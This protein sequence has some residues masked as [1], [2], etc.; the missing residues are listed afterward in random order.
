MAGTLRNGGTGK[1]VVSGPLEFPGNL[2]FNSAWTGT[3]EI[4]GSEAVSI[5]NAKALASTSSD[6]PT[7][8]QRKRHLTVRHRNGRNRAR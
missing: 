8:V 2:K 1:L 4:T 6:F 7:S 3:V 5:T